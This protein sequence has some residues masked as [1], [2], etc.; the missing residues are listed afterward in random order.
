MTTT[1]DGRRH[2]EIEE[3]AADSSDKT[4]STSPSGGVPDDRAAPHETPSSSE[5]KKD[6][7]A[8][9]PQRNPRALRL[10]LLNLIRTFYLEAL[11]RLPAARLWSTH[12]RGVLVAGH[13]YGPF[14]PVDNILVN[15]IWYDTA[16]PRRPT[17]EFHFGDV[18][19]ISPQ[20]MARAA[21]RSLEGLVAFLLQLCPSLSRDDALWHLHLSKADLLQAV[22]SASDS[23]LSPTHA[24]FLAAA[25]AAHHPVPRAMAHFA[26]SV[27]PTVEHNAH[28]L[29][30]VNQVLSAPD[31]DRL[32][33]MLVPS[34]IPGDLCPPPPLLTTWVSA[35][36]KSR[37]DG[38]RDSQ[39]TSRQLA[40]TVL[41][42]YVQQTGQIYELH[43][44]CGLH[45]FFGPKPFWHINFLARP[46][47]AAGELPIYFFA[48]A[49]V[50]MGDDNEFLEDDIVLCCPIK[51]SR[52]GG[53]EA[54]S[55]QYIKIDHPV[56][57]EHNGGLEEYDDEEIGNGDDLW[58]Y[59]FP[60]VDFVMF[61]AERD[62]PTVRA[63][64]ESFPQSS[65]GDESI[66]DFWICEM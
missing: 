7:A 5:E 45:V 8:P 60:L 38:C 47:D 2:R 21:H 49:T 55:A 18:L 63:I 28:K 22:A 51:P 15:A 52:I 30:R 31:L 43:M 58:D 10:R 56:D 46:K 14:S 20:C 61:D 64:E 3:A 33:A 41:R 39:E 44:F 26:S 36:I 50:P 1:M 16:F 54:C 9:A 24:A 29:L 62:S 48:E 17:T 32:S 66:E 42:K 65:D 23:A 37:M 11:S 13:C 57:T 59:N 53:C 35:I 12:A 34:P 25:E 27:L 40:E 19:E 4:T 6:D